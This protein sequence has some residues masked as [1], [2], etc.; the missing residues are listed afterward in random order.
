MMLVAMALAVQTQADPRSCPQGKAECKPWER[1]W[2][3]D[4]I[5]KPNPFDRFDPKPEKLGP[6]PHTL[7]I[8]DGR[9]MTRMD[10]KSGEACQ[11]AKDKVLE[12]VGPRRLP[13]GA[14][15]VSSVTVFCV[16]R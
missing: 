2:N 6:G 11:R 7:V 15:V 1:Q 16:P 3:S 10:Y 8:G 13:S 5:V 4:P 9:G 12:Q 14:Y